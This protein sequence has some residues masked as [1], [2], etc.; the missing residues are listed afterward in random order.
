[1]IPR[2][3]IYE[4]RGSSPVATVQLF[5]HGQRPEA[6]ATFKPL[7]MYER[8]GMWPLCM[9]HTKE[10]GRVRRKMWAESTAGLWSY[11]F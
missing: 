2:K 11:F 9:K 7:R 6:L 10:V 3:V 5:S 8:S 4:Q 1:M